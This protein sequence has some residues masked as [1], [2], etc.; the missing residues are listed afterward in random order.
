M[1]SG[2]VKGVDAAIWSSNWT[3]GRSNVPAVT[4]GGNVAQQTGQTRSD[5][6][7]FSQLL[8]V[9]RQQREADSQTRDDE[10]L[11]DF[12][13]LVQ[14][15]NDKI[16]EMARNLRPVKVEPKAVP[17]TLGLPLA[18]AAEK[19]RM[20]ELRVKNVAQEYNAEVP[21]GNVVAQIPVPG[22]MTARNS[23]IGLT[24][25][26]GAPPKAEAP[27][28]FGLKRPLILRGAK[29]S[30]PVRP[31]ETDSFSP[32][33]PNL[34]VQAYNRRGIALPQTPLPTPKKD[35]PK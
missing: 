21:E 26:R 22:S 30:A 15:S 4:K 6:A 24:I 33:R 7:T 3:S 2:G 27:G 29:Q 12:L 32:L 16:R 18:E 23:G 11:Q 5:Q 31:A 35:E 1:Q 8:Q 13:R 10:Q 14:E 28:L 20:A 19:L 25:S 17:S 9:S 34:T